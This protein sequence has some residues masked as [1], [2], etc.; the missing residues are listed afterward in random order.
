MK[1]GPLE[2]KSAL[3][4]TANDRK[5]KPG[6]AATPAAPEPS[7][8]VELSATG[9]ALATGLADGSFDAEK[10]ERLSRAIRDGTYRID[11]EAIADKLIA[12]THDLLQ[13]G[14]A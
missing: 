2:N 13:N 9:S 6:D 3:A 12:N 14:K 8:K 7:T 11:A 10:V 4:A 1:I 5:A